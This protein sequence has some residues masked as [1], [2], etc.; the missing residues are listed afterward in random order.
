M[1]KDKRYKDFVSL[2]AKNGIN[3]VFLNSDEEHALDVLVQL[4][5]ISQTH[6]KIFAGCLCKHVGNMPE[7]IVALSE[8]IERG[9]TLYI[10]L[11]AF[12]EDSAKVSNL[13]KRLAYYKS[14]GKPIS[15][16][17]TS[18]RPFLNGDPERKEVHFTIGDGKSYRIET[19]TDKRTAEC[20]F[21]NPIVAKATEDFFDKLFN[22]T[23]ASEI[24]IV[25]LFEDGNQ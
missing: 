22:S 11:N 6:I 17:K 25:K 13:Y 16:K 5:N 23:D 7:Y 1:A 14:V 3:R 12:D 8:F 21:N 20:N 10:L 24:D 19:D 9:G 4:F 15:V 2:L 18:A